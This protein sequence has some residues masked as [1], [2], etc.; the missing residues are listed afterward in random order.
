MTT[1][2]KALTI[3]T[4]IVD[5]LSQEESLRMLRNSIT[6]TMK[7]QLEKIDKDRK[8][9]RGKVDGILKDIANVKDATDHCNAILPKSG[10]DQNERKRAERGRT[11]LKARL[12]TAYPDYDF[13]TATTRTGKVV[14][15]SI[16]F[17]FVGD[18]DVREARELL[19][20][21]TRIDALLKGGKVNETAL[22]QAIKAERNPI[23]STLS[24]DASE[25][26][27]K[28]MDIKR[29]VA[30]GSLLQLGFTV[31]EAETMVSAR[32]AA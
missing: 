30:V 5:A 25:Q 9:L 3:Q 17:A 22:V 7:E 1:T 8:E 24:A 10:P 19:A 21:Q 12:S 32:N 20:S 14:T 6:G 29:S 26:N 18:A 15:S 23:E 27:Q 16:T 31:A 4:T 2:K 13:E 28:L 11:W